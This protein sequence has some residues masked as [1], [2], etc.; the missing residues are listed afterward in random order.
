M[1]SY[2]KPI[3]CENTFVIKLNMDKGK[4]EFGCKYTFTC[5]HFVAEGSIRIRVYDKNDR[6][7]LIFESDFSAPYCIKVPKEHFHDI[8]CLEDNTLRYC[9]QALNNEDGNVVETDYKLDADWM[10]Q[11][12]KYE[13]KTGLQDEVKKYASPCGCSKRKIK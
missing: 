13:N 1:N 9:I 6:Q 4:V 10:N 5:L 8:I 7:K 11:V 12:K 3:L 2:K